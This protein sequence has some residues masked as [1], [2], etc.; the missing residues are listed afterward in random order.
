[1]LMILFQLKNERKK[2]GILQI[3]RSGYYWQCQ[4]EEKSEYGELWG[5]SAICKGKKKQMTCSK[6]AAGRKE[7]AAWWAAQM[8]QKLHPRDQVTLSSETFSL[9]SIEH[10][11]ALQWSKTVQ[12]REKSPLLCTNN[13]SSPPGERRRMYAKVRARQEWPLS[14]LRMANGDGHTKRRQNVCRVAA[15]HVWLGKEKITRLSK[16][17]FPS[18]SDARHTLVAVADSLKKKKEASW[19]VWKLKATKSNQESVVCDRDKR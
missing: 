11:D 14:T 12:V 3:D 8:L 16:L 19:P 1:M 5:W 18:D 13:I 2:G 15:N 6:K 7:R 4:L 17:P 10:D 9:T